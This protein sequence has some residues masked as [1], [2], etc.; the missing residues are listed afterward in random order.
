[1]DDQDALRRFQADA[2]AASKII[3][4]A[5]REIK[6]PTFIENPPLTLDDQLEFYSRTLPGG[7]P[8]VTSTFDS[9]TSAT[10]GIA[11]RLDG[12][13]EDQLVYLSM[14]PQLLTRS[15][16][17][18]NGKPVPYQEMTERLRN[19]ILNLN[20]NFGINPLTGRYELVVRGSGNNLTESQRALEWI[21]LVLF[22]PDW[23][24][25][26][27]PRLRELVEQALATLHNTTQAPEERWV[28]DPARAYREQSNPLLLATSSFMT[29]EHNVFR[30]HWMLKAGGAEDIYQFLEDLSRVSGSRADRKTMLQAIE[31]GKY[32]ALDK[33]A[34][35]SKSLAMVAAHDL[36]ALLPEIPDSS[37]TADWNDLC[38]EI[39][40]DLQAGPEKTLAALDAVRRSLLKTGGARVFLIASPS[41]QGSLSTRIEEF[42][43][44]L[45][46][47]NVHKASYRSGRR[48]D[49]RLES[50][51]A[52]GAHPFFVGL[53]NANSQG[54]VFLNS[55]PGAAYTDTNADHLLDFLASHLY[56]GHGAHGIFMKTW[57][58]GLA[59]SNGIRVRPLEG[60]LNYYAERTPLLPQTLEF[61]IGELKKAAPDVSLVD[62]TIAG[63]FEGTRSALPY[64]TRGEAMAD[65]LADGLN[66]A[67]VARFHR[68]ILDLRRRPDLAKE[69]FARM[70]EV[71]ERVLPGM[72]VPVR[73]VA[74]GV[75]FVIGPEKQLAAYEQYLKKSEGA[76]ARL[77]RL[78]PRDFWLE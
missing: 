12:V 11:L 24:P 8:L 60:R 78:Y 47:A 40:R 22:D 18:E 2:D 74:G 66:P 61:V 17:I 46:N 57:G 43:R 31:N 32:A 58:A 25:E 72:G 4:T 65:D 19:E 71:Y 73:A 62:Y 77:F 49:E 53:L 56:A 45:Q 1:M 39:K 67:T 75:Y 41:A 34:K 44:L 10:S 15:G 38:H 59:Y 20:A 50:R 52:S 69:L 48:I 63:A 13:P 21:K 5:A 35:S 23:R 42:P 29:R 6:P 3:E 30:L 37:L 54:G 76:D 36:D 9:M 28:E 14:L 16:V 68:A 55:A 70:P 27:L 26:N 33:L 51:E 64:E 7:V